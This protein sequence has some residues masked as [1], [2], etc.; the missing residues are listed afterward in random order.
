AAEGEDFGRVRAGTVDEDGVGAG[1]VVGV[2]AALRLAQP[3]AGD[4]GLHPGD[5]H[6]VRAVLGVL[7]RTDLAAELLTSCRTSVA[8]QAR[9]PEETTPRRGT[10]PFGRPACGVKL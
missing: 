9:A 3:P 8:G 10:Y 1:A 7:G 6:E 2:G 4:E 5:H